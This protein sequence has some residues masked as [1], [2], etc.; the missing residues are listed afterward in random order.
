MD[1]FGAVAI[2]ENRSTLLNEFAILKRFAIFN[3]KI[4][5]KINFDLILS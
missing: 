4:D 1:D 2:Y 3:Y 5:N